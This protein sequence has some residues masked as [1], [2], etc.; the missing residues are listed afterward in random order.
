MVLSLH[1]LKQY[2]VLKGKHN[3]PNSAHGGRA[4]R[5]DRERDVSRVTTDVSRFGD[6]TRVSRVRVRRGAVR[7][8]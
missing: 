6:R 3:C 4:R 1:K 2:E 8:T 7:V 5:D